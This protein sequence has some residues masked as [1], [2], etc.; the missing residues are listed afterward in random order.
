M[1][2][3]SVLA[4]GSA[5]VVTEPVIFGQ[6]N[7]PALRATQYAWLIRAY[8][9][10]GVEIGWADPFKFAVKAQAPTILFP[11]KTDLNGTPDQLKAVTIGNL[12]HAMYI[13]VQLWYNAGTTS[14]TQC[15]GTNN[16]AKNRVNTSDLLF[17]ITDL[18]LTQFN[19]GVPSLTSG[20][21]PN[22]YC[23][24]AKSYGEGL[25]DGGTTRQVFYFT[26]LPPNLKWPLSD[27]ILGADQSRS[28][29]GTSV[30]DQNPVEYGCYP[31]SSDNY[32]PAMEPSQI[33]FEWDCPADLGESFVIWNAANYPNG[34][35][36]VQK[37]DLN[38][39]S[40]P[41]EL[42]VGV[43]YNTRC[44]DIGDNT[45]YSGMG[46]DYWW[47]VCSHLH[48]W[49][50]TDP[51]SN[52]ICA[53][54]RPFHMDVTTCPP[55]PTNKSQDNNGGSG[56]SGGT[57]GTGGA[58]PQIQLK[59]TDY[60]DD[61]ATYD[62]QGYLFVVVKHVDNQTYALTLNHPPNGAAMAS[63]SGESS[64]PYA[65]VGSGWDM[66]PIIVSP[67][68]AVLM[69]NDGSVAKLTFNLAAYLGGSTI[70]ASGT[71]ELNY[72]DVLE[73]V[74]CDQLGYAYALPYPTPKPF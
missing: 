49:S 15:D 3:T 27:E 14:D 18:T 32:W 55:K 67:S 6:N 53:T 56:G 13:E 37:N 65:G 9:Q 5:G 7:V 4:S 23:V 17:A 40:G 66:V 63:T 38:G 11:D 59:A 19:I 12:N 31:L 57:G 48:G 8:S 1:Y 21:Q 26:P 22:G 60:C 28:T 24:V 58:A 43:D 35:T 29:C 33:T 51:D 54:P 41:C 20:V 47:T 16:P 25:T 46:P 72:Y 70:S 68:D 74:T 10:D 61:S 52:V 36:F 2:T 62:A 71:Y 64:I 73:S 50:A 42:V 69:A 30:T 34:N 39:N 44:V 45:R